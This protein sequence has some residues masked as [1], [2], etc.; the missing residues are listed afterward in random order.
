MSSLIFCQIDP[1]ECLS[2]HGLL[3]SLLIMLGGVGYSL[4]PPAKSNAPAAGAVA[5]EKI[6]KG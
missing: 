4:T 5:E 3:C 1:K 2:A 6:K